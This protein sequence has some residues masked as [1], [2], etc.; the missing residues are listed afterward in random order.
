MYHQILI[1]FILQIQDSP[2]YEYNDLGGTSQYIYDVPTNSQYNTQTYQDG[3]QDNVFLD[4]GRYQVDDYNQD[5]ARYTLDDY[6]TNS[7]YQVNDQGYETVS[8]ESSSRYQEDS[9]ATSDRVAA[10]S[11]SQYL[12][13]S[14]VNFFYSC[15]VFNFCLSFN[16]IYL[17][18]YN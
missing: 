10:Q 7:R 9:R 13:N 8:L 16:L 2:V 4:N 5:S 15:F 14:Q 18:T 11:Q 3:Y 12:D 6:S 17:V 1:N